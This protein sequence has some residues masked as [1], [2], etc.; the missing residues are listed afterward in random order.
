MV[1]SELLNLPLNTNVT[2]NMYATKIAGW[3]E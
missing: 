3:L 2:K 1:W